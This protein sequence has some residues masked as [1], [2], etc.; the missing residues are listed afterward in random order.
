M[1]DTTV[2]VSTETRERIRS[3]GGATHEDTI[4]EALDALESERF[5]K[6]AEAGKQWFDSLPEEEQQRL[7]EED[8]AIDLLFKGA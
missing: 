6:E 7:R 1:K 3:F 2:K 4:I 5:W 8:A